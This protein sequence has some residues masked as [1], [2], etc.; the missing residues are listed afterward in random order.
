MS[1]V[2]DALPILLADC[3]YLAITA[4]W[5]GPCKQLKQ[6]LAWL[7]SSSEGFVCY[8]DVLCI[9]IGQDR[10]IMPD[11]IMKYV[12]AYPTIFRVLNGKVLTEQSLDINNE[13]LSMLTNDDKTA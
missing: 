1:H 2:Q 13:L 6:K 5:C 11:Y 12:H 8:G 10:D 9:T 4:S 7:E 3:K